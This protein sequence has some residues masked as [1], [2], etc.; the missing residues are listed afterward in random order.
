[1]P[2]PAP[3]SP[4]RVAQAKHAAAV[5]WHRPDQDETARD[6][7]A[8][9]IAEYVERY[10]ADAPPLTDDQVARVVALLRP[11]AGGDAR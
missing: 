6:F 2:R 7:A 5:R 10:L 11:S 3:T 8:E 4:K 1:M 9:A